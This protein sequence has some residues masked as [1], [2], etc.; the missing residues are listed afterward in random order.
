MPQCFEILHWHWHWSGYIKLYLVEFSRR[1]DKPECVWSSPNKQVNSLNLQKSG[2][3]VMFSS[4]MNL[5]Y[6]LWLCEIQIVG[7]IVAN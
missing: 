2:K 3:H 7:Q 5:V 4:Q 1:E 6:N